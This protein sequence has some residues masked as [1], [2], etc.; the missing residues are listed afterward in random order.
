MPNNSGQHKAYKTY[1]SKIGLDTPYCITE[2][3]TIVEQESR[4]NKPL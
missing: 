3:R 4:C 1:D 2:Q